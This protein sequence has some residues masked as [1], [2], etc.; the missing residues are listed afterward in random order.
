M[1]AFARRIASATLFVSLV[2][3]VC[4]CRVVPSGSSDSSTGAAPEASTQ[5]SPEPHPN[6]ASPNPPA[7]INSIPE[8]QQDSPALRE[9]LVSQSLI[10]A[11]Q[12]G[13]IEV[14]ASLADAR[15][16]A[17]TKPFIVIGDGY[18]YLTLRR[19]K[20]KA[21]CA[22]MMTL[23]GGVTY[24]TNFTD[25]VSLLAYE[26][27]SDATATLREAIAL[28]GFRGIGVRLSPSQRYRV[29]G[30]LRFP[31]KITSF[32]GAGAVLDVAIPGGTR[33]KPV[34]VFDLASLSS[35]TVLTDVGLD[36]KSSP[37]TRGVYADAVT[38]ITIS[39]VKMTGVTFRVSN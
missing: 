13:E 36:L 17:T 38:D 21:D 14:V 2:M 33:S 10:E 20:S 18:S 23:I 26:I 6:A 28:A 1:P 15:A 9:Y 22:D 31:D 37:F 39:K 12:A 27:G 29:T 25:Y 19:G 35:G 30:T 8:P 7:T 24:G 32:D 16:S 34:S 4:S 11:H 5:P 3:T